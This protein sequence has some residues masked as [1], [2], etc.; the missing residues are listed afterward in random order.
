MHR[1]TDEETGNGSGKI[2]AQLSP[3]RYQI[4]GETTKKDL[5]A[6]QMTAGD[7]DNMTTYTDRSKRMEIQGFDSPGS[8]NNPSSRIKS[9]Q[10]QKTVSSG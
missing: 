10:K 8:R 5:E 7:N 2:S 3:R 6:S 1:G 9:P 4:S